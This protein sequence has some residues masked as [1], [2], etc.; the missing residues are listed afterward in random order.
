M[1]PLTL[2]PGDGIGP[3]IADSVRSIFSA[4]DVPVTWEVVE[5]SEGGSGGLPTSF[6]QSLN[7]CKIALKG[8]TTTPIGTGHRSL[9]VRMRQECNLYANVRPVRTI[10]G[11]Q[12]PITAPVEMIIV[13][14]NTEDL[15][16]GLEYK[17]NDRVAHG[18]KL[19]TADASI[20]IAQ[21]AFELAR[22]LKRRKVTAVHKANIM[23]LTD[24]LF[25]DCCRQVSANFKDIEFTDIIVDNCCMQ[26]V[27]KPGQ[28]DV[29]VT[30]NLYGDIISDL[31]AGLVGGLGVAAGANIG[32]GVAV[33]EAVHGSAP[34]IAGK[35]MA[36]PTAL[37]M[38][39]VMLLEHIGELGFADR[40]RNAT[41]KTLANMQTRTRDLGG[42]MGTKGFTAAIIGNL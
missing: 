12:G 21:H 28:F 35:D 37:I 6:H 27:T 23:K 4:A 20:R 30:E 32:D 22:K 31:A 8:P 25:L 17:V 38:S 15:Y 29:I 10:P 19:I 34:D 16:A 2:I 3:E 24:G 18:I 14:E 33:F 7:K 5:L 40:I 1:R 41:F 26:M 42:T 39:S 36:N 11:V 9:N 13:R